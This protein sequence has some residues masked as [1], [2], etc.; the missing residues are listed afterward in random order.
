MSDYLDPDSLEEPDSTQYE[1]KSIIIH[2]GGAYGGH[3]YA[4][5]KDDLKE[6]NWYLQMPDK[7]EE[8]PVTIEKKA[9][10]AEEHMTEEQKKQLE[11]EMNK[12]NPQKQQEQEKQ[13][14]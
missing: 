8:A 1:L 12:N 14:K 7:F 6:G 5:I 9:F 13:E 10:N 11:E 3:Y 2:R 4:Y